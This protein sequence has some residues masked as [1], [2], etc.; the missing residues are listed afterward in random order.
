MEKLSELQELSVIG[1]M[2]EE[3]QE[4]A[5]DGIKAYDEI[6]RMYQRSMTREQS[7]AEDRA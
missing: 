5:E 3:A 1:H 7:K 4:Y 6:G 2:A